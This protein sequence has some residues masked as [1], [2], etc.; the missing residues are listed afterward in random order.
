MDS[1]TGAGSIIL[2]PRHD[3]I[4]SARRTSRW[5]QAL[6]ALTTDRILSD[7][8]LCRWG[9]SNKE[10]NSTCDRSLALRHIYGL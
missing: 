10:K 2:E 6:T 9:E 1:I 4:F 3:P 8:M 7:L 5:D